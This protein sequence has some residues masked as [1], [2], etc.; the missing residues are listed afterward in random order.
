MN[1][2]KLELMSLVVMMLFVGGCGYSS[3]RSFRTD[4]KTVQVSAFGS[5]E[6]R[7]RIEMDLT[8]AIKKHIQM[9]T[10]YKLT[11]E[12]QADT[13][14]RGEVLEVRQGTLGR[15]FMLNRPRETQLTLVVSFEWKDLRTGKILVERKRWLQTFDYSAPVGENEAIAL[16]GVVDRMAKR[17]VDQMEADW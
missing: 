4:I 2:R 16:T 11:D 5:K 15:D 8:E 17:I 9:E 12:G 10:P 7:R 3:R 1:M 6:F 14:L 13:V